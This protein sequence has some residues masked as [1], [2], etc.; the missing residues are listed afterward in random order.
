[1]AQLVQPPPVGGTHG[2]RPQHTARHEVR[3]QL[4]RI[5]LAPRPQVH[6][7][8][9][10]PQPDG[11]TFAVGHEVGDHV[12]GGPEAGEALGLAGQDGVP[13]G[14]G[15]A[16]RAHGPAVGRERLRHDIGVEALVVHRR[17]VAAQQRADLVYLVHVFDSCLPARP[18]W[19]HRRVRR[20]PETLG[21]I[22]SILATV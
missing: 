3:L 20:P 17:E 13:A 2:D 19:R 7:L 1:M 12:V 10:G 11:A 22:V 21:N 4:A 5:V 8:Q 15:D 6:R 9:V 18:D 16:V 14:Q